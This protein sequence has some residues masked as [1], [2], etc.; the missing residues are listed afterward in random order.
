MLYVPCVSDKLFAA[1][2]GR[3][4]VRRLSGRARREEI[5]F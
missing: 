1:A 3:H 5:F 4:H 2:Y